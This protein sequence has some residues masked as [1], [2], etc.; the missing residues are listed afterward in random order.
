M[1]IRSVRCLW[2][3]DSYTEDHFDCESA[4]LIDEA[5]FTLLKSPNG[6]FGPPISQGAILTVMSSV[7]VKAMAY[8]VAG[9]SSKPP[10]VQKIQIVG[11]VPIRVKRRKL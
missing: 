1:N 5:T 2:S 3:A 9:N 10:K 6:R 11:I 7:L 4:I 8:F